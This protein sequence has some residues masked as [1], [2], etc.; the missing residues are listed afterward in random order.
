MK[1]RSVKKSN[2][3]SKTAIPK[4]AKQLMIRLKQNNGSKDVLAASEIVH[5]LRVKYNMK[6]EDI[7]DRVNICKSHVYNL[8]RLQNLPSKVHDY[9]QKGDIPAT[10]ALEASRKVKTESDIISAVVK[11]IKERKIP[12]TNVGPKSKVNTKGLSKTLADFEKSVEDNLGKLPKRSIKMIEYLITQAA[13]GNPL[14]A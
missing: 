5:T 1:A 4:A 13:S 6:P 11:K 3:S 7:A 14:P 2:R 10:E 12:V 8:V 9:I